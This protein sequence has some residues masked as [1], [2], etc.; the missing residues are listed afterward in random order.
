MP[1]GT[2]DDSSIVDELLQQGLT[3]FAANRVE[4]AVARW[5]QVLEISPGEPRALDYLASAGHPFAE[6]TGQSGTPVGPRIRPADS[7]EIEVFEIA[8]ISHRTDWPRHASVAHAA[9]A[10]PSRASILA[11]W[12]LIAVL[13]PVVAYL[14]YAQL[15]GRSEPAT[16]NAA[17]SVE[18]AQPALSVP[19]RQPAPVRE[20]APDV[21]AG[22]QAAPGAAPAAA[23]T[24]A[25]DT[26]VVTLTVSPSTAI[27]KV[28]GQQ[29]ARGEYI[30]RLRR[31]GVAHTVE[32]SAPRYQT[33]ELTFVDEAP[34][35]RVR[36]VPDR[37][38]RKSRRAQRDAR[39][40]TRGREKTDDKSAEKTDDKADDKSADKADD[41]KADKAAPVEA[42]KPAAP[43]Q[44]EPA[45]AAPPAPARKSDNINP[46]SSTR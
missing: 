29:V 15:D 30:A 37:T 7:A 21:Q 20:A 31:D 12:L 27:I 43:A 4:Q 36:L 40:E 6:G 14:V 26:Y 24:P 23:A 42:V 2:R 38:A 9:K 16:R 1:F 34:P 19:A 13:V 41:K 8:P 17:K 5:R 18:R 32:I 22:P 11:P 46:W 10:E 39:R 25:E 33:R 28:D 45:K 44:P 3:F 35:E